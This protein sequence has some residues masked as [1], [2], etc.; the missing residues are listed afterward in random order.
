MIT[1]ILFIGTGDFAVPALKMLLKSEHTVLGVV[2]QP[3]RPSGR[4]R[5]TQSSPVKQ[6]ATDA[7]IVIHQPESVGSPDFIE[8]ARSMSPDIT[9]VAS[10]G[11]IIPQAVLDIPRFGNINV[12]GSL[13]PKYRGAAP[14]H[15]ALFSGDSVTG[16]T[17]MLMNADLD[18]GH[19]LL[20]QE[21]EIRPDDDTGSLEVRLA[22]AGAELLA[23]TI[24]GLVRGELTP[25]PQDNSLASYAPSIKRD[26]CRI[27]W[28]DSAT[29]IANRVRGCS[30]KPG[31]FTG[32][33]GSRLK[34]RKC[35]VFDHR[36]SGGEAGEIAEIM[37]DG[38]IVHTGAGR[39][40]VVEVQPEN[41]NRMSASEFARGYKVAAGMTF[42]S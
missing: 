8:L 31:A 7:G 19:M 10:F 26:D 32:W 25:V 4:G 42:Q 28:S 23:K 16:V 30:P 39:L 15:Y 27:A 37:S 29:S 5:K 13:L 35:E 22:A 38:I 6:A 24:G 1:R 33:Q 40:L 34:I 18:T 41:R 12:H 36:A 9:V 3:D 14:I 20:K 11:Q 2:T 17:T 21:I